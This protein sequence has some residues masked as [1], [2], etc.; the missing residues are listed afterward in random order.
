[1]AAAAP[2]PMVVP[3]SGQQRPGSTRGVEEAQLLLLVFMG[4]PSPE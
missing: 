2:L 4:G 1:M 3:A